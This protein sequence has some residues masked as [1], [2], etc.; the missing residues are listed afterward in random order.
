MPRQARL[1]LPG[2]CYHIVMRGIQQG[3]VFKEDADYEKMM[4]VLRKYKRR[5][6]F[7]L[8]GWC[9]MLNHVHLVVESMLLPKVMHAINMNY[10]QA[11]LT[12]YNLAGHLWQNRYK[13]Y[14]IQ[15]DQYLIN[16]IT[17][18]E[19]NPVRAGIGTRPEDYP[20][21]SYRAR[22]LGQGDT[23]LLDIYYD[24]LAPVEPEGQV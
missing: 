21:S 11:F 12:K 10:A 24:V 17:Y 7:K 18:I 22:V 6:D 14:I 9:L 16:C 13:S 3:S 4:S 20:W 19:M 2:A 23:D 15:K 5:Y 1:L 8:Y